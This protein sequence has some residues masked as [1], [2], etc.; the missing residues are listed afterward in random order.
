[1]N[2]KYDGKFR[3]IKV[4]L[5]ANEKKLHP[6][7]RSGYFAVDPDAP[8]NASK[9]AA[10][11][12]G[13]MTMQHGSP[14]SHQIFFAA[15]V[16]PVG[17]AR[18]VEGV[19][20]RSSASRKKKKR[21]PDP[22]ATDFVEVQR[23]AVDFAV[24]PSQLRFDTKAAGISHGVMNV[25]VTSFDDDG[26][27][28]TSIANRAVSDLTPENYQRVVA[29]GLRIHQEID[30]PVKAASLRMAVQDALT[31]RRG[32]IEVPLPIKAPPGVEQGL[33]HSMPEI[34]PD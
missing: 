3:K 6:S 18:R 4:S 34:E 14:Q 11:G 29:G 8:V 22:P 7:Y 21:G 13:L 10:N 16:V 32:T 20:E 24:T 26:T 33:V 15:R 30:V 31:G 25:M 19:A 5:T 17:K 23:Y 27:A 9:E 1:V 28:R 2:K 12:F